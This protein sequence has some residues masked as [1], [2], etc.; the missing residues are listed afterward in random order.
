MLLQHSFSDGRYLSTF[1]PAGPGTC[2]FGCLCPCWSAMNIIVTAQDGSWFDQENFEPCA[3][4]C[5]SR[6]QV[7]NR[8]KS[9]NYIKDYAVVRE[10]REEL[11]KKEK[12]IA[13]QKQAALDKIENERKKKQCQEDMRSAGLI[14]GFGKKIGNWGSPAEIEMSR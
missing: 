11:K 8:N 5:P 3:P 12:E 13:D 6:C 14:D 7:F 9:S 4:C 2:C 1:K 10:K